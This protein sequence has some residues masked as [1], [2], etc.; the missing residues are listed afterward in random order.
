MPFLFGGKLAKDQTYKRVVVK[1]GSN[2]LTD[3]D[4]GLSRVRL[5]KYVNALA[6][7]RAFVPEVVLVSSGAIAAG[8]SR[9]NYASRPS[10]VIAK[11][12]C[13]AV[14]QGL[15][16]QAYT[17]SFAAHGLSVAQVLLTRG[18]FARRESY[19]NALNT[20]SLL[21]EKGVV[22]IINEND[23]VSIRE[24]TFGENDLLAALVATLLQADYLVIFSSACGLYDRDPSLHPEAKLIERV[25]EISPKI[26]AMAS[27]STSS[28]GTGGMVAKLAAAELALSMGI[29]V[30]IGGGV[31][32]CDL[33]AVLDGS[34]H[35]TYSV[36]YT[37]LTLPTIYS[38]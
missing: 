9:L 12:A 30:F 26:R 18:D 13:A 14:G 31:K 6:K 35:G 28:K 24:L 1:L 2:L 3:A 15:L 27:A 16:I 19:N 17:E 10:S 29:P 11:Q 21:L 4:Q 20:L 25:D 38:V 32:D 37:H 22:P 8:Y 33:K 5:D 23:T 34:A 7:L 36:S